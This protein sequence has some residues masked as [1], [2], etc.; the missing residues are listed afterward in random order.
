MNF[1]E[2]VKKNLILY[3]R[4]Y[5]K[6]YENGVFIYNGKTLMKQHILSKKNSNL[7][8][9]PLYRD[10]FYNSSK[11]KISFHKYFH[12]LNSSQALCI[13]LFFP[14]IVEDRLDIVLEALGIN[15][16]EAIDALFEKE[17]EIEKVEKAERKT[18]FDFFIK[19]LLKKG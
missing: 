4:K 9:L 18:S 2:K 3:K 8:I 7:N 14:L 17:S 10:E 15:E 16:K 1:Q 12:H 13:N 6:I 19:S 5:L 11:S